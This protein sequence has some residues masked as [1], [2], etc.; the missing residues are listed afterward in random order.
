M[1][2]YYIISLQKSCNMDFFFFFPPFFCVP[3]E[4]VSATGIFQGGGDGAEEKNNNN[5]IKYK[6]WEAAAG[7]RPAARSAG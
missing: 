7:L 5:K 4:N 2:C 3:R 6:K 1:E